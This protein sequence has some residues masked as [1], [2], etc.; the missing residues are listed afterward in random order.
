MGFKEQIQN[1]LEI[2]FNSDELAET[3][4]IEGK[5]VKVIIDENTFNPL[6]Q[7]Q[8]LGLIEAD[9][10]I[11]GKEADFSKKMEPGYLLNVDGKELIILKSGKNMGVI[12]IALS[13][14]R[15]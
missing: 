4:R 6:K 3:H 13:Q 7:G 14:N 9:M 2:F 1:D 5:E 8:I 15:Q 12:E 11:I 10:L